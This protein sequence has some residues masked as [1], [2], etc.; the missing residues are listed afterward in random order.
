MPKRTWPPAR[1]GVLLENAPGQ[2]SLSGIHTG[3]IKRMA[4]PSRREPGG[5]GSTERAWRGVD[6]TAPLARH[7]PQAPPAAARPAA[8]AWRSRGLCDGERNLDQGAGATCQQSE[9]CRPA[10]AGR[11]WRSGPPAGT[12]AEGAQLPSAYSGRIKGSSAMQGPIPRPEPP[13]CPAPAPLSRPAV[14]SARQPLGARE[15][16]PQDHCLDLACRRWRG[17][18]AGAVQQAAGSRA[19][20]TGSPVLHQRHQGRD[21]QHQPLAQ[22]AGTGNRATCRSRRFSST[23]Q[24]SR[25]PAGLYPG[26]WPGAKVTP[27]QLAL[28]TVLEGAARLVS[29]G[30]G[31]S[32]PD[33]G[34]WPL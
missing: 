3:V 13:G 22:Q 21:H 33:S 4:P 28:E 23:R 7:R 2:Q 8:A 32:H 6:H 34:V 31:Q 17:G 11:R 9:I 14:A 24:Q 12:P 20:A 18:R 26:R 16:Q 19:A 30:S 29:V 1:A 5:P 10:P 27:S 15:S 25:R